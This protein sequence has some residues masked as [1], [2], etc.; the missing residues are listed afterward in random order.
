MALNIEDINR[1]TSQEGKVFQLHPGI[2]AVFD[3]KQLSLFDR[4]NFA[5]L[6]MAPRWTDALRGRPDRCPV[7]WS[8]VRQKLIARTRRLDEPAVLATLYEAMCRRGAELGGAAV[9][10]TLWT[11]GVICEPLVDHILAGLSPADRQIL[12][13]EQRAKIAF[14]LYPEEQRLRGLS[15]RFPL[16]GRAS[17]AIKEIRAGRVV[18]RNLRRRLAG[19]APP[20]NDYAQSVLE[21]AARL[22]LSRMTYVMTTLLTAIAGAPGTVA[23]CILY[24]LLRHPDWQRRIAAELAALPFADLVA[25]PARNAPLTDR[26]LKEAMRLWTFPLLVTRPVYKEFAVDDRAMRPG[27]A[28]CTSAYVLHRDPELWPDPERFDPDR[29]TR[30][31]RGSG[32]SAFGWGSRTCVGAS[33][34]L[35]QYFLFMRLVTVD[36]AVSGAANAAGDIGTMSLDGV[37]APM[38]FHGDVMMRDRP[39]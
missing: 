7:L 22:G 28:Y 4:L 23:A 33:F 10:L 38:D 15:R 1:R 26:F 18:A 13:D 12:I 30:D 3:L 39:R 34:G 11:E 5:D 27:Q 36:A 9:D 31:G 16:L 14:V 20:Q 24:E 29:W 21:L 8:D 2:L 37:A 25:D 35:A 32:F 17:D 6:H 19:K